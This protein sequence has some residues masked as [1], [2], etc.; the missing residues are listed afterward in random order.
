MYSSVHKQTTRNMLWHSMTMFRNIIMYFS[1]ACVWI[2][3]ICYWQTYYYDVCR[4]LNN[5]VMQH[6]SRKL[7][8]W[9]VTWE[10]E[11]VTTS[12]IWP[13]NACWVT[14]QI[15]TSSG[16][17]G[18]CHDCHVRRDISTYPSPQ[19]SVSPIPGLRDSSQLSS[20]G[21]PWLAIC[22]LGQGQEIPA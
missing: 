18:P 4:L 8:S 19:F 6:K 7:C 3:W 15:F 1:I 16:D 9:L 17:P 12:H 22:N 2:T 10:R 5:K 20:S 11:E 13:R 14:R 21:P